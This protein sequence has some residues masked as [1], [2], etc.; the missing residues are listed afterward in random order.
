P[1][2]TGTTAA[3]SYHEEA[4]AEL[5]GDVGKRRRKRHGVDYKYG[6]PG[7]WRAVGRDSRTSALGREQQPLTSASNVNTYDN[8]DESQLF[9]RQQMFSSDAQQDEGGLQSDHSNSRTDFY[10]DDASRTDFYEQGLHQN[11]YHYEQLQQNQVEG[12]AVEPHRQG[13]HLFANPPSQKL[14]SPP[15]TVPPQNLLGYLTIDHGEEALHLS[16]GKSGVAK[17]KTGTKTGT[18]EGKEKRIL[19]NDTEEKDDTR[20]GPKL[21]GENDLGEHDGDEQE[22]AEEMRGGDLM[23][24]RPLI[25]SRPPGEDGV[26]EEESVVADVDK[27]MRGVSPAHQ[28]SLIAREQQAQ[29]WTEAMKKIEA[30]V[31][32]E[33]HLV[34]ACGWGLNMRNTLLLFCCSVSMAGLLV[35]VAFL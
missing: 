9:F 21:A 2:V 31:L 17:V 11:R 5:Q 34:T 23:S 10:E 13:Q 3:F 6:D 33:S 20:D 7:T 35:A 15:P 26:E 32:A 14:K 16:R 30:F 19:L 4:A 22:P 8:E 29:I 25:V 1:G 12:K 27:K 24:L 28:K 18:S